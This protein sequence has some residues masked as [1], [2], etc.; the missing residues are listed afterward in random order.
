MPRKTRSSA[1]AP[2]PVVATRDRIV[3]EAEN[4]IA[5]HGIEG[6]QVK[7]IAEAIGIRP[8]SVFAH[9]SGRD[10]IVRAVVERLLHRIEEVFDAPVAGSP[11]EELRVRSRRMAL[12]LL[13]HPADARILMRDLAHAG[14]PDVN[15]FQ[16]T[17]R[18]LDKVYATVN[19]VLRRGAKEGTFRRVKAETFVSQMLGAML[20]NLAWSGWDSTGLPKTSSRAEVVRNAEDMAMALARAVPAPVARASRRRAGKS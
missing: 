2:A 11:E 19:D 14:V 5:R 17:P 15:S 18:L 7:G 10:D 4:L 8:P 6:L 20:A 3:A 13:D 12:F 1:K 16:L 9:F